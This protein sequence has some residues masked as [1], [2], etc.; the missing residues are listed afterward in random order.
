MHPR[1][2]Q[3]ANR[4]ELVRGDLLLSPTRNPPRVPMTNLIS[5]VA[6]RCGRFSQRLRSTSPLLG[7]F[8]S[9]I[10]RTRGSTLRDV[11]RAA[12]FEQHGEA[13]V[14][15][16][17]HQRQRVLL[18]QRFAAGQFDQGQVVARRERRSWRRVRSARSRSALETA[19]PAAG[20][21]ARTSSSAFFLPSVKAYAVSQ[22][23]QR[24]LQAVSRTKTHGSPA[25]VLSP[26]K[27]QIDFVDDQRVGHRADCNGGGGFK[28]RS[29]ISCAQE[30][31]AKF[32][33]ASANR[34]FDFARG[35]FRCMER[36]VATRN[37]SLGSRRN[38]SAS[39]LAASIERRPAAA[40]ASTAQPEGLGWSLSSWRRMRVWPSGKT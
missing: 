32:R 26:C 36:R 7:H 2:Q 33:S 18:E 31:V 28:K 37:I 3:R 35:G 21:R 5:S 23:E 22:Y 15:K 9:M 24:R 12:G 20:L 30:R 4:V 11:E 38:S 27:T 19:S 17:L 29:E 1:Q 40:S 25:K 6:F 16:L 13:V 34:A 14:A 8:K 39:N 10:R